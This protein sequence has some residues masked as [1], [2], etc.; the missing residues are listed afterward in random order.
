MTVFYAFASC[1]SARC[2]N[3]RNRWLSPHQTHGLD[4]QLRASSTAG[5]TGGANK[6]LPINWQDAG[7]QER[8]PRSAVYFSLAALNLR[9]WTNVPFNNIHRPVIE[10]NH[11]FCSHQVYPMRADQFIILRY[12]QCKCHLIRANRGR[13]NYIWWTARSFRR[14][15]CHNYS[16]CEISSQL[17][18]LE[19]RNSFC[20]R[21]RSRNRQ[22]SRA[23]CLGAAGGAHRVRLFRHLAAGFT[24]P[25]SRFPHRIAPPQ[26]C[27]T[28]S[29]APPSHR[30]GFVA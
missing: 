15:C 30:S 12:Q 24:T 18:L 1:T 17:F 16:P 3:W 4:R 6:A 7:M 19:L 11:F 14:C 10:N 25:S 13:R 2:S 22:T 28:K 21:W 27:C 26:F 23:R 8:S 20:S 5:Y 29:A 9:P